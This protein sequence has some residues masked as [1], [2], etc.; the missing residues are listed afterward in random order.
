MQSSQNQATFIS[1]Y[2]WISGGSSRFAGFG[3]TPSRIASLQK[4]A[5]FSELGCQDSPWGFAHGTHSPRLPAEPCFLDPG[6]APV[7]PL[8]NPSQ[9]SLIVSSSLHLPRYKSQIAAFSMHYLDSAEST[10]RF[11]P[12]ASFQS[13]FFRFTSSRAG[14]III[15][16]RSASIATRR[17]PSLFIHSFSSA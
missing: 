2:S 10:R 4:T 5:S 8:F 14:Q 12:S 9:H 11:I 13:V 17:H 15:F 16:Y 6:S 3:R 7:R 1:V